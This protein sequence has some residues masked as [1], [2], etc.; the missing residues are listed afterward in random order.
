[1]ALLCCFAQLNVAASA[2]EVRPY[3]GQKIVR[4]DLKTQGDLDALQRVGAAILNC[5][6][7]VGP[8]D[9]LVT[10][11]QLDE[12]VGLGRRVRVLHDD[13]QALVDGQ[14]F[15]KLRL[16]PFEDFFLDYHAYDNGIGSIVWYMN[17]LVTRYPALASMENVGTTLE[18]RTIRGLRITNDAVAGDKP[19]VVYFGCEHAR[20]WI[21]STVPT[22]VAAHLL[23]NY[24][25]DSAVTD[26][27]DNVEFFLIP[28]FN[29]DGYEH[30]STYRMW[31]KNRRNNGDGTFGVDL[32]RNWA[33]G[34]GGEGSS[35]GTNSE[36]Y[37][38][39][40]PFSEPETQVLRDFFI[41][42]PNVRAQLD[43]H[44]YTQ[45]ILWPYG[46]TPTLS[47]DHAIYEQIGFAMQSLIFAVHGRNYTAGPIYTGIYPASGVSVDWTYE[48]QG[49]LSLSFECRPTGFPGFELPPDEIIPN[50]EELLPAILHLSDSD[51][52]R[53]ALRFD[54]PY[55]VPKTLTAGAGRTIAVNVVPQFEIAVPG[56]ARMYYRYDASGP[57]IESALTPLG[58]DTYEALLP[59]TN[60]TSTPEFY[61]AVEG[62]GGAAVTSPRDAPTEA[63]YSAAVTTA[64]VTFFEDDLSRDPL[65]THS[66]QWDWGQPTGGGGQYGGP[67]PTAGYTGTNVY[68]YNLSGD[69]ADGLPEHHLT[70][71]PA[72]DCT[73][74]T[75]VH[76]G[77]W[78][79]LGV[80]QPAY[81]HAYVRVS[82][83][84]VDWVRVWQNDQEITDSA[85]TWQDIDISAV[86]DGQPTVYVRWTM[87]TTDGAWQYCGWNIDDVRLRAGAC[88]GI[89]GDYDGDGNVDATDL[90]VFGECFTGPG[91]P[92][93][94]GCGVFDF[95][96]DDDVDCDDWTQ[97][98]AVWTFPDDPPYFAPCGSA[99]APLPEPDAVRKNR[100]VSF[101]PNNAG[102]VAFRVEMT[103]GPG[104]TG[105]VGWVG[106]PYDGGCFRDDGTPTGQPCSG[107]SVAR[108]VNEPVFR[109]W[110]EQLIYVGDCEIVP[111][112]TFEL[113]ATDDAV[114]FSDPLVVGTIRRPGPRYHGDVVGVSTGDGFTPPQ[115]VVNIVDIQAQK[116]TVVGMPG[117]PH[118]TW[119]DVHG[120]GVG[121]PPNFI[122]NV[123]DLQQLL[124]AFMGK[125]YLESNPDHRNPA[126]CP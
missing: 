93:S 26:L 124:I 45:L 110:P 48:Q 87:G 8:M 4:I 95:D 116:F 77:F 31:R 9:V 100:Y 6:P 43:I 38:G 63:V 125:T 72:I 55:G 90:E 65:W 25:T 118:L 97:F 103:A 76:L 36:I 11:Q 62:D 61:F 58:G 46:Y 18:G 41:S 68:G 83:N 16:D 24:G 10:Q 112:A 29:V 70:T 64:S 94:P 88:E 2:A 23:D 47:A 3:A 35:S 78:R 57:F 91:G 126:D 42:H 32:N 12:L 67:D 39:T 20:E 33:Q 84:G 111:V 50:N 53:S 30:T 105:V 102:P 86:A 27:V 19:A 81:D 7:G 119:T 22:Y 120:I 101:V 92:M 51:W 123:S 99:S 59:A 80:E 34:W 5:H 117:A 122:A 44:S 85:W 49:I 121:S 107:D 104:A 108:V 114:I 96:A 17:E 54:F 113:R 71:A 82:N 89:A 15:G 74:R 109:V 40:A 28:V 115:G 13:A 98:E 14:G 66:G 69:Y 73:D 75:G 60:C 52:V 37:R 56:T 106:G 79:W 1:M 21:T